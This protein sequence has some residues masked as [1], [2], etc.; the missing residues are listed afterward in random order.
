VRKAW[1]CRGIR[2]RSQKCFE[3]DKNGGSV[4]I[5][6]LVKENCLLLTSDLELSE[7]LVA[8]CFN[9]CRPVKDVG[10]RNLGG[11]P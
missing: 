2:Q 10:N 3:A 5:E 1:R 7:Y 9:V 6:I 4:G 11:V 8:L